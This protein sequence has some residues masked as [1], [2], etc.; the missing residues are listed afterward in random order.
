[1]LTAAQCVVL[2]VA[3]GA[4]KPDLSGSLPA[5]A[6]VES[7]LGAQMVGD[8][9]QS[10]G[11]FQ[12]T[13]ATA[14][15]VLTDHPELRERRW[16]DSQVKVGLLTDV[17]WSARLAAYRL[18]DLIRAYG[19]ERGQIAYNA[20]VSGMLEGRAKWRGDQVREAMREVKRLRRTCR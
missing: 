10:Y 14:Q 4:G 16:T 13:V 3:V 15:E 12:M 1:V 5:V 11:A 18:R 6:L 20:G 17:R 2:A 7:S 8:D 9:G 19:W